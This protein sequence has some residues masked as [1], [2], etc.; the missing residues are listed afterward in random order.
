MTKI[1]GLSGKKQSGK[2]T[3]SNWII[4]EQMVSVDMVSYR[5]I[6]THGELIVP[7]VGENGELI[8]GAF[9]PTSKDPHIQNLMAQYVWPVCK[10][11]SFADILKMSACAIFGL[12]YE[13]VN[14]TNEQKGAPTKFGWDQFD[15]FLLDSTR[16]KIKEEGSWKKPMSGRNILQVM[17]TDIFRTIYGDVWVDACLKNIEDDG[18]ELAVITDCRFPNEVR[19]IQNAG[20]KVIRLLRSPFA[21]QDE[22]ESETALDDFP[23]SEYDYVCDNTNMTIGEQNKDVTLKM[24]EWGYDAWKWCTADDLPNQKG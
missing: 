14:G 18:S 8:E 11:Y 22:H 23:H 4:G 20:G 2:T 12:E 6:S 17:G 7:C 10:L 24:R 1:L 15:P 19:G 13:Q 21:G 3:A 9:D 16:Q 5:K